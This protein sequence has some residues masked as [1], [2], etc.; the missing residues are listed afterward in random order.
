M[1][2]PLI[3]VLF[4]ADHEVPKPCY[5]RNKALSTIIAEFFGRTAEKKQELVGAVDHQDS[6]RQGAVAQQGMRQ[7]MCQIPV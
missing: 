4:T 2:L 6:E 3:I 1:F 5:G 7:T